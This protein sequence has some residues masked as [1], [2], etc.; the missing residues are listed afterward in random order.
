LAVFPA[1]FQKPCRLKNDRKV[2]LQGKKD[3]AGKIKK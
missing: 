3:L 2:Y 1:R